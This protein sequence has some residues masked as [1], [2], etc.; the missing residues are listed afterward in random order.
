MTQHSNACHYAE[1]RVFIVILN[2][3]MLSDI[4]LSVVAPHWVTGYPK[5]GFFLGQGAQG[6]QVKR[7]SVCHR[8]FCSCFVKNFEN[9]KN[10]LVFMKY[11]K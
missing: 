11:Y 4:M 9:V 6:G 3:I 2:V 10:N 8:Q 7:S 1:C 5:V